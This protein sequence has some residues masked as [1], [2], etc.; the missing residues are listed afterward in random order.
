MVLPRC[1]DAIGIFSGP[2]RLGHRIKAVHPF[3]ISATTT[4][5]EKKRFILSERSDFYMIDN[6]LIAIYAFLTH[7][8]TSLSVDEMLLPRY[9][10]RSTNFS[11]VYSS[12][13]YI[14]VYLEVFTA[15]RV[16]ILDE[17]E[18]ISHST[19]IPYKRMNPTILHPVTGK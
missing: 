19:N 4:A 18:S 14:F 7:M 5:W 3:S 17:A 6:L 1:R 9:M 13:K 2:S 12:K 8:L 15:G 11:K 10:N 16:Q